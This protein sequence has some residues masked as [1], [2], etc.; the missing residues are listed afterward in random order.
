MNETPETTCGTEQD[1]P[2]PWCGHSNDANDYYVDNC[3]IPGFTFEC[4]ECENPIEILDVDYDITVW[5]GP[6]VV[7]T[8]HLTIVP[9]PE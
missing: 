3:L 9:S 2:C 1:I 5:A 6:P 8:R 4:D 7:K